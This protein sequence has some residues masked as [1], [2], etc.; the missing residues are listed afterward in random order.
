MLNK[1]VS[2]M[3]TS[4]GDA[5]LL[6]QWKKGMFMFSFSPCEFGVKTPVISRKCAPYVEKKEN[7]IFCN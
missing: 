1:F 2:H 6:V 5:V 7:S 3:A 4:T